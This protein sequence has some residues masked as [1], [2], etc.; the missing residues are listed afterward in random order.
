MANKTAYLLVTLLFIGCHY[1]VIGTSGVEGHRIYRVMP[2][3]FNGAKVSTSP[4]AATL[5][6]KRRRCCPKCRGYK[7][8]KG[9]SILVPRG[10][11]VVAITDMTLIWALNKS[12]EQNSRGAT[13]RGGYR[14][15]HGWIGIMK[16]YDDVQLLFNDERDNHIFYYHLMST[17]LVPGFDKGKCKRPKEYKTERWKRSPGNCGGVA[18]RTVKKGEVIGLSGDTGGG[19]VGDKHF[20]LGIQVPNNE[21]VKEWVAPEEYFNWENLPSESDAYLFPVQSKMYLEKIGYGK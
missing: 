3:Y 21:G 10:T 14:K 6:P 8:K 13:E 9:L 17:P 15:S 19:R 7:E 18:Y 5:G 4:N 20:S 16:P 1:S 11:P 12:A 2:C